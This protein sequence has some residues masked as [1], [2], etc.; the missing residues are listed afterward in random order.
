MGMNKNYTISIDKSKL[1][2]AVIHDYLCN[3]SYWAKGRTLEIVQKSIDNSLCFG[4]YD[5]EGQQVGFARVITDLAIYAY[6]LDVF[7][8]EQ[9]RGMG[10]GKQLIQFIVEYPHLENIR[11]WRLD[12]K[13][14]HGLYRKYGFID[15]KSPDKA[16]EKRQAADR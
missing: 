7:V 2:V 8:L 14:A 16:M 6:L 13:D 1:N 15:L 12:T 5:N 11:V 4:A 9:Y 10:I 3:R